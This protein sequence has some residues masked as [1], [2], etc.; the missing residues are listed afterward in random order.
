MADEW[1]QA[2]KLT[3]SGSVEVPGQVLPAGTYWFKLAG[4]ESERNIIP[5]WNVDRT[6]L[7]TTILAIPDYRQNTPEKTIVNFEDRPSGQPEAIRSWF[8]SGNN[9]GEE[10]VYAKKTCARRLAKQAG[11]AL[12]A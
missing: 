3:I 4:N 1:E 6:H 8:Y 7:V 9:F 2:T 11:P 12:D 5:M 10:F